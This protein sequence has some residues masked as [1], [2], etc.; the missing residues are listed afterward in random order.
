MSGVGEK[1]KTFHPYRDRTSP[2]RGELLGRERLGASFGQAES[3]RASRAGASE[4]GRACSTSGRGTCGGGRRRRGPAARR[5][6][7]AGPDRGAG[8]GSPTRPAAAAGR[9]PGRPCAQAHLAGELDEHARRAVGAA[10]RRR[11]Q[12]VGDLALHHHRPAA[13][14]GQLLDRPQDHRRRHRVG[15]V[16]DHRRRR[17]FAA[18]EVEPHRIAPV[19]VHV[20]PR[21]TAASAAPAAV[22]LDR[23]DVAAA[24][25]SRSV[26]T[27]SPAPTSST[28]SAAPSSA[29]RTIASSRL[30]SARKFWPS[31]DHAAH[32]P[33]SARALASTVRSS[34][35]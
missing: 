18:G 3:A 23:V 32:Q 24:A 9:R 5:R 13:H 2:K 4:P 11:P 8:R 19:Q 16:G 7:G 31:L 1:Y 27:P 21:A 29:S 14:R 12:P 34:S 17:R 26:S 25:A 28:T 10:A 15:Q 33:N 22:D 30:G 35:S 20:R 6:V